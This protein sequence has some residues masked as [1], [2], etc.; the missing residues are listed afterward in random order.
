MEEVGAS[1]T[2]LP[3]HAACMYLFALLVQI[4]E[5]ANIVTAGFTFNHADNFRDVKL[6]GD[7]QDGVKKLCDMLGWT[8]DLEALI[9]AG[10]TATKGLSV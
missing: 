9:E 8:T 3:S 4:G 6:L 7:C 10:K 5:I 2:L 1:S